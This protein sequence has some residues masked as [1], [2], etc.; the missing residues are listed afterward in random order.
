MRRL[1][2]KGKNSTNQLIKKI[3]EILA[4]DYI[5]DY[6]EENF[7]DQNWVLYTQNKF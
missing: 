7:D 3:V 4:L 1:L 6:Y 5:P 2:I